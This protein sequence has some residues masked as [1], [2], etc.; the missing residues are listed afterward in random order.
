MLD[1][2]QTKEVLEDVHWKP[3]REEWLANAIVQLAKEIEA[4]EM[5]KMEYED[6]WERLQSKK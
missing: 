1:P 2:E 5:K 6:E 3:N 4:L